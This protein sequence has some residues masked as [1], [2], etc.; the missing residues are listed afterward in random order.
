[1]RLA[2]G[3]KCP[4]VVTSRGTFPL[5]C[6]INGAVPGGYARLR[7]ADIEAR[8]A[9][10][11][12]PMG[13]ALEPLTGSGAGVF[14]ITGVERT[15]TD[16]AEV[17][18]PAKP[19]D[20]PTDNGLAR[21]PSAISE[22]VDRV[23]AIEQVAALDALADAFHHGAAAAAHAMRV[24]I[25]R[26]IEFELT[27]AAVR[28]REAKVHDN[29]FRL[30]VDA[31]RAARARAEDRRRQLME[32][33]RLAAQVRS[34]AAKPHLRRRLAVRIRDERR[35]WEELPSIGPIGWRER[36]RASLAGLPKQYGACLRWVEQLEAGRIRL[37]S[38][39]HVVLDA[40]MERSDRATGDAIDIMI[41]NASARGWKT[42]VI[43]GG[44]PQWRL[45]CAR[46]AR[47]AGL[48]IDRDDLR[49]I[50]LLTPCFRQGPRLEP[51]P[52]APS[53]SR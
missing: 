2:H 7:K 25:E 35:A 8:I 42:L 49:Q 18:V 1:L 43:N 38:G 41:G 21:E 28:K 50:A 44:T 17:S 27:A 3:R 48:Q 52:H 32:Q 31:D 29:A 12:L 36:Y 5:L 10:I 53:I 34:K 19:V 9:N 51:P 37:V 13:D 39:T 46:A 14:G 15:R 4:V 47:A 30:I 22:P 40:A 20:T 26:N 6:A 16:I 33:E 24:E 45:A 11:E 23:L